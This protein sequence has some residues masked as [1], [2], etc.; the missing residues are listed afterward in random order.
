MTLIIKLKKGA[1]EQSKEYMKKIDEIR[2]DKQPMGFTAGSFFKNPS[3]D[4]PAGYL[5]DQAGL[6]GK[7]IG[8]A[9]ISQKHANF[10]MN[11][12]NATFAEIFE[13]AKL[14]QEEVKRHFEINLEMEVK[15]IGDL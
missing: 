7:R 1:Q 13:L 4:K 2:R 11:R 10:F 6:K 3:L 5:I 15:I 12:G 8:D 14:A 9:E